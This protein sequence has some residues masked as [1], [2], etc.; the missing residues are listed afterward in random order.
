MEFLNNS[1]NIVPS[2]IR[3]CTKKRLLIIKPKLH[4]AASL[5]SFSYPW[6]I[7]VYAG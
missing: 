2:M 5:E 3:I 4:A 6:I 7:S 1:G